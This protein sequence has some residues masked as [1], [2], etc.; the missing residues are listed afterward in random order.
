M[1]TKKKITKKKT[2]R[3]LERRSEPKQRMPGWI[4]LLSGVLLGLLIAVFGYING[5]VPKPDNPNDK[6]I[7]QTAK[8][9][10]QPAIEDKSAELSKNYDF[11]ETLQDMEVVVDQDELI[12]TQ[13]RK[14]STYVLQ[15]GAFKNR[16][17]AGALKAKVAF[18][19]LTANIQSVEINHITWHRVRLGPYTSG[20][21]ADVAK[22]NLDKN[23]FSAIIIKQK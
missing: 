21:K 6:P 4:I 12:Q 22:R 17:D 1:T 11:Y 18:V 5:W 15:L 2:R 10:K 14:P 7:A 23:G 16:N 19:G 13:N 8:T 20:R 3:K 9:E